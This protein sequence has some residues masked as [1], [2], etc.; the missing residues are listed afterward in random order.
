[1]IKGW[2]AILGVAVL[3]SLATADRAQ[4]A[5]GQ[6]STGSSS[7]DDLEKYMRHSGAEMARMKMTGDVDTDFANAMRKQHETGIRMAEMALQRSKDPKAREM[8]QKILDEQQQGLKELDAWLAEHG[9]T[10]AMNRKS[11]PSP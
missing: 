11:A 4:A 1:M 3:A 5:A 2:K 10:G 9:S 8:A 7:A 6:G